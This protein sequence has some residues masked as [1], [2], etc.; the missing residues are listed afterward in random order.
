MND[1]SAVT[2]SGAGA[3][4]LGLQ[5]AHVDPVEHGDPLVGA[6]R[7]GQLAVADVDGDDVRRAGA[8]QDVGEAAGGRAGVQ[9][10]AARRPAAPA[11]A[12]SAPASLCP[13]R[14]A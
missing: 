10:P 9:A 4:L 7:P 6:Q 12:A 13:P 14:E 11:K 3:D 8:Q 2:R 5:L 1:R